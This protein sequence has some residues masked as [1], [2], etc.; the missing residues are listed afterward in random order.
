M[1]KFEF[2]M[3]KVLDY[4]LLAEGW[5]KD[6]YLDARAARLEAV[7]GLEAIETRRGD[8]LKTAHST[9]EDRL[10]MQ[11]CLDKCDSDE[12]QQ[13]IVIDMLEADEAKRKE[14][15]TESRKEL[16]TIEKLFDKAFAE[17]LVEENRREQK[18]LDE[19][20]STRRVG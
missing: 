4:R 13:K 6:A 1:A 18:E 14:E 16:Q 3:Q 8:L 10:A 2:R 17:W 11:N 9:L 20:T 15:W 12:R 7:A 5:A 19:W